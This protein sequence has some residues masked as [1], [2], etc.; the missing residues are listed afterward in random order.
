MAEADFAP[1]ARADQARALAELQQLIGFHISLANTAIKAHF[2]AQ[3]SGLKLTQKQIAI[4]WLVD[5]CPGIIQVDL[6]RHLGVKRAT[7]SA[8]VGVLADRGLVARCERKEGDPRHVPLNLT[9]GGKSLLCEARRSIERHEAWVRQRFS[10]VEQRTI[11]TL[12]A[13]LYTRDD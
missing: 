13:R 5:G 7:M 8:M 9:A 11:S 12:M 2:H 1:E 4:L 10:L 3:H 6:A